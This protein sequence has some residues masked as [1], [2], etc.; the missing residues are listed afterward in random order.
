MQDREKKLAYNRA[1]HKSHRESNNLR[2]K[3]WNLRNPESE[4][5]SQLR[6]NYGIGV[7]EYRAMLVQ[8]GCR[9]KICRRLPFKRRLDVDHDHATGKVRGLLCNNCN[10]GI[11]KFQDSVTLLQL[12]SEYL[13]ATQCCLDE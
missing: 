12:A 7:V 2:R 9:C 4:W 11:G 13:E 8:Q 6:K 1:Y 10:S 3:E 5:E